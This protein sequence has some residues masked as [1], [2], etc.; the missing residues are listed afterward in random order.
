MIRSEDTFLTSYVLFDRR[1]DVAE[2]SAVEQAQAAIQARI[3]D[4]SLE[5]PPGVSYA[6]AGSYEQ[7]LRSERRLAVLIPMALA[8]VFI[9][10]YL[11]FHRVL[12]SAILY[13]SVLVAVSGA[14]LLIW[15]Y[16]QPWFLDF[17]L[18]GT[19][20]RELFQVGTLH[21]SVAVWV[22]IIALI[23]IATDDG[24]VLSTYLQQ[25]FRAAPP[26]TRDEVR[27]RTLEAGVRRLR[28]LLMTTATTVLALLPVITSRG[29][30]ADIMMP[31]ALPA[32]GGMILELI[33]LF[34]VPVLFCA[35]EEFKL[36]AR[37]QGRLS[38]E[39]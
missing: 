4:G 29:R 39:R 38:G 15:L 30:G 28:P 36:S 21:M 8:L 23:G 32:V 27:A 9:L 34:V 5:I 25:R 2:V 16:G 26:T 35:L 3:A 37:R 14:F 17:S 24:V 20:M 13:S 6:F 11:Q 22:G 7:Q 18:L 10:L 31:I 19:S 33:T 1:P 12:L